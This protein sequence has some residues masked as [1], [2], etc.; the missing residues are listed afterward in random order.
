MNFCD[1]QKEECEKENGYPF[2]YIILECFQF[3]LL[4]YRQSAACLLVEKCI[5]Y[6]RIDNVLEIVL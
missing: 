2:C 1:K 4:I 6:Y 3:I 5:A